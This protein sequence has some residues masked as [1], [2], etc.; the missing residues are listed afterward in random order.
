[1]TVNDQIILQNINFP[2]P[3][4]APPLQLSP[5]VN[6]IVDEIINNVLTKIS[7][8]ILPDLPEP[9]TIVIY[10]DIDQG[11]DTETI[12]YVED[13]YIGKI[14]LE[15]PDEQQQMPQELLNSL[16]RIGSTP[17]PPSQGDELLPEINQVN[18]RKTLIIN[19]DSNI[20]FDISRTKNGVEITNNNDDNSEVSFVKQ[21]PQHPKDRLT[22]M[23][24]NKTPTIEINA[25]VLENYSSS[26][27]DI[28]IDKTDKNIKQEEVLTD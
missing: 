4:I 5:N 8:K 14:L 7:H 25:D 18:K 9:E 11:S 24:R 21:T 2:E 23:L 27:A 12:N 19:H 10:I 15:M 22:R 13:D 20:D 3:N 16:T 17:S 28:N 6:V 26:I 1:M